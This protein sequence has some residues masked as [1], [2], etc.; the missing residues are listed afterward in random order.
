MPLIIKET[1][2]R[3]LGRIIGWRII[4]FIITICLSFSFGLSVEDSFLLSLIDTI[5]E[6]IIHYIYERL[7]LRVKSGMIDEDN[8][9][10][11]N[12]SGNSSNSSGNS[13]N[14]SRSISNSSR[15]N[16][17]CDITSSDRNYNENNYNEN[18]YT[19]RNGIMYETE[20]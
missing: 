15:D 14:N 20:I 9:S 6:L 3:T 10:S 18:N 7:W 11:S 12:S 17:R 19:N 5:A 4:D 13:S 16:N 1:K 2:C 8:D